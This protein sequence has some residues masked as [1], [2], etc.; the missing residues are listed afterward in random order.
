MPSGHEDPE[1]RCLHCAGRQYSICDVINE[2]DLGILARESSRMTV[3]AGRGF[4]E[5]GETARDFFVVTEGTIR[6][7]T[8]LPDGRRQVTGFAERGSFLGLA[9]EMSYAFGAEALTSTQLCRFPHAAMERLTA[10]FPHLEHRLRIEASRE[11]ARSH[12]RMT[13]LGRKTAQERLASFL[14]ERVGCHPRVSAQDSST[15]KTLTLPMPRS[16]IADYLG[17]TIETVSRVFSHFK[18]EGLINIHS[19]TQIDVL[20]PDRLLRISEGTL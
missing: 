1:D 7:F 5:E 18:R 4:I 8:L 19:I 12:A 13:L 17:L 2:N 6:L 14:V 9:A 16:D 10:R 20:K 15:G 11:L 3:P